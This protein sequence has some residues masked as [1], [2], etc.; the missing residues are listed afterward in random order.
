MYFCSADCFW[1][2]YPTCQQPTN[3]KRLRGPGGNTSISSPTQ[4]GDCHSWVKNGSCSRGERCGF[5]HA[6][7]KKGKGKGKG[8][9]KGDKGNTRSPSPS[10]TRRP[11]SRGRPRERS[12]SDRSASP[13]GSPPRVPSP[14][15]RIVRGTS[16]SGKPKQPPCRAYLKGNCPRGQSCI[17][18]HPP[19]CRH[20][21]LGK[22]DQGSKCGYLHTTGKATAAGDG[23]PSPGGSRDTSPT[24]DH[25]S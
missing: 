25:H 14:P 17:Y 15:R 6:E 8:K 23:S 5:L 20:F 18:Y 16:P 13:S 7:E 12:P 21:A 4:K 2:H 19:K 9:R 22:C 1:T 24:P 3:Q 11:K 10:P